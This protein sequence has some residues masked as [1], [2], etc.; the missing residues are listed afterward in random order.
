[1]GHDFIEIRQYSL[2]DK[3]AS[4]HYRISV[5]RELTDPKGLVSNYLHDNIQVGDVIKVH[6][7]AG[8]FFFV[9]RNSPVVLISGGVVITPMKT[10]LEYQAEENYQNP[11]YHLHA[12]EH[13]AQHSFDFRTSELC[14]EH[15]WKNYTWYRKNNDSQN[16]GKFSGLMDLSAVELPLDNGDFYVCGPV[17]F[18]RFVK[19]ALLDF[20]VDESRIHYEVFGP[21]DAF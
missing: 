9:D 19:Q 14:E 12:C 21:Y 17:V 2:S 3:P 11:V 18:M 8:D 10:M 4:D 1:M 13:K 16:V 7:P 15:G 6:P 5:K 20:G